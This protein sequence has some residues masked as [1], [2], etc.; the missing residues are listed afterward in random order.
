MHLILKM[1]SSHYSLFLFR[2]ATS[3]SAQQIS[4]AD[5][6]LNR[7]AISGSAV[8]QQ[9]LDQLSDQLSSAD[10]IDPVSS[11]SDGEITVPNTPGGGK[12]PHQRKRK[13]AEKTSSKVKR[14]MLG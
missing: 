11:A 1:L 3:R 13:R 10:S 5:S 2:S 9:K 8:Y 6:H 12:K 14:V 7:S 4:S